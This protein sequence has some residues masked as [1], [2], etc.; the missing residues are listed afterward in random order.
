[1]DEGEKMEDWPRRV[2]EYQQEGSAPERHLVTARV[3]R[4]RYD[5][6][7]GVHMT[8]WKEVCDPWGRMAWVEKSTRS[9][10]LLWC[11]VHGRVSD[12]SSVRE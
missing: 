6:I 11:A 5:R 4:D 12:E 2:I 8:I 7:V 9:D 1:M 3:R 10:W